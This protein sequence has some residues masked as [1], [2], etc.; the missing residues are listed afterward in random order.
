MALETRF[1]NPAPPESKKRKIQR[2]LMDLL[3]WLEFTSQ[4]KGESQEEVKKIREE[5]ENKKTI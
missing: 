2:K 1:E 4:I 5:I 3:S